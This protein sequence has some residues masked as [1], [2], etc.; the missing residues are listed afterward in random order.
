MNICFTKIKK[1]LGALFVY[2]LV[3]VLQTASSISKVIF[4]R[5][6]C[7]AGLHYHIPAKPQFFAAHLAPPWQTLVPATQNENRYFQS[8]CLPYLQRNAIREGS[9]GRPEF[10][11]SASLLF[12]VYSGRFGFDNITQGC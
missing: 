9:Y 10:P 4:S 8:M 1:N 11:A 2:A 5:A 12:M 3:K 6:A 7:C